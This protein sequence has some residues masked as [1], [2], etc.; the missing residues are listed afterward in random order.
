MTAPRSTLPVARQALVATLRRQ[1]E[2]L[3]SSRPPDDMRAISTGSPALDRLLPAGGLAR[4]SLVDE[5]ALVRALAA[6]M[7]GR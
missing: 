6:G 7:P 2:R 4:G 1:V 3:E 5:P